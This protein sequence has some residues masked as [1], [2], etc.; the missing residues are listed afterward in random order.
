MSG[1]AYTLELVWALW[2][3]EKS[4]PLLTIELQFL[5][6]PFHSLVTAVLS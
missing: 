6:H 5:T 1:Q 3:R 4:L 2:R